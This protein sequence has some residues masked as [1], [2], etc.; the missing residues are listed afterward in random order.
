MCL[1][2]LVQVQHVLADGR[3][4]VGSSGGRQVEVSLAVLLVEGIGVTP[5]DWLVVHTGLA[6]ERIDD[7]EVTAVLAARA[8]LC[9]AGAGDQS[10][11]PEENTT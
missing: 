4:A 7:H 10:R 5:G 3:S 2:D 8:E 11:S 9:D 1:S 6:V